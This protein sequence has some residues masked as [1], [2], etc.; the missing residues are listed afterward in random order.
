MSQNIWGKGN[1]ADITLGIINYVA[2]R[3]FWQ[4]F[5]NLYGEATE[6]ITSEY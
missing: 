3:P 4:L 1:V 5:G 6:R 2:R